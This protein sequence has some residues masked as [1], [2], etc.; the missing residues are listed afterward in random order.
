MLTIHYLK[1]ISDEIFFDLVLLLGT[2][3]CTSL[4][5][6]VSFQ[7]GFEKMQEKRSNVMIRRKRRISGCIHSRKKSVLNLGIENIK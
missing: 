1:H 4:R 2:G 7:T 3:S 6:E 5:F